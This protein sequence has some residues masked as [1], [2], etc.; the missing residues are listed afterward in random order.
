MEEV[1]QSSLAAIV[2]TD[3]VGFSRMMS[4]DEASTLP[5]AKA[6]LARLKELCEKYNGK[7]LKSTGD[8]LLMHFTS[9]VKAVGCALEI[10]KSAPVTDARPLKHR[11]GIHLGDVY[12][13]D[14][15]VMGDGVNIAARLQTQADPGGICISKTV[16]DVVK[17]RLAIQATFL[18]PRELKNITEAVPIYKILIAAQ[19]GGVVQNEGAALPRKP[20]QTWPAW[21]VPAA[22]AGGVVIV[23]LVFLLALVFYPRGLKTTPATSG[24]STGSTN[25]VTVV[26]HPPL[27]PEAAR[28]VGAWQSAQL[29]AIVVYLPDGRMGITLSFG[30]RKILGIVGTWQADHDTVTVTRTDPAKTL[31]NRIVNF[32]DSQMILLG[33]SGVRY[34]ER[35]PMPDLPTAAISGLTANSIKDPDRP[36]IKPIAVTVPADQSYNLGVTA[37]NDA[38]YNTAIAKFSEALALKPDFYPALLHRAQSYGLSN[39]FDKALADYAQLIKAQPKDAAAYHNRAITEIKSGKFQAA[40]DDENIALGL[41]PGFTNALLV[42]GEAHLLLGQYPDA[43]ADINAVL[44]LEPNN[45]NAYL[46]RGIVKKASGDVSGGQADLDQANTLQAT[47]PSIPAESAK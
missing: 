46:Y 5:R 25:D 11:I 47:P 28:I 7:V 44:A 1:P 30:D 6:E 26:P 35:I 21:V 15:D 40:L 33:E 16:Y 14:G 4:E 2:F 24:V 20:S 18:G 29:H 45:V 39:A 41:K 9:A 32:T 3:I 23:F 22:A 17:N 10:Q 31:V 19:G 8:G 38:D 36:Q 27:S 43:L 12:L 34:L 13:E 42:R 37:F